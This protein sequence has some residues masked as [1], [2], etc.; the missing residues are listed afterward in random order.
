MESNADYNLDIVAKLFIDEK[1]LT[2][3]L[4]RQIPHLCSD[5]IS[6]LSITPLKIEGLL[7]RMFEVKT[8]RKTISRY[9]AN[10]ISL[11]KQH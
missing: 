9:A 4:M 10:A 5:F 7:R 2:L 1:V 11:L 3:F 8:Y 6:N